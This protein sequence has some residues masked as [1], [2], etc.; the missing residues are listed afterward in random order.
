MRI[1]F[2]EHGQQWQVTLVAANNEHRPGEPFPAYNGEG[3]SRLEQILNR[4]RELGFR[5]T[6]VP[7]DKPDARHFIID[8]VHL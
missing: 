7:Y 8:V 2:E 6:R 3:F 4:V 1:D 5:A